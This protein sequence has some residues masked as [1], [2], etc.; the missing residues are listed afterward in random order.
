MVI[1]HSVEA[2]IYL[3]LIFACAIL[4]LGLED[5]KPAQNL[6]ILSAMPQLPSSESALPSNNGRSNVQSF[7]AT[8]TVPGGEA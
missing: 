7:G 8:A 4:P 6:Q 5:N 3:F 2:K 1:C